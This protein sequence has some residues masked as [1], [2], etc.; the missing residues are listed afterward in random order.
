MGPEGRRRGSEPPIH[1]LSVRLSFT[2]LPLPLFRQLFSVTP[3]NPSPFLSLLLLTTPAVS[4]I[5]FPS[6]SRNSIFLYFPFFLFLAFFLFYVSY[7]IFCVLSVFLLYNLLALPPSLS[8]PSSFYLRTR[9]L[10]LT[11]RILSFSPDLL[12]FLFVQRRS[13]REA[14]KDSFVRLV[15]F[16]KK[17]MMVQ[18]GL[19]RH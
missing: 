12:S 10:V 15:G 13:M 4:L 18:R 6:S 8:L 2:S 1:A 19:R 16:W 9:F 14:K 5:L 11:T 3:S 17:P 7:P